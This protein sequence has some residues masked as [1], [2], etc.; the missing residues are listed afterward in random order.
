MVIGKNY[1][2]ETALAKLVHNILWRME[3]QE[4]MALMVTDLSAHRGPE[5]Q[6]WNQ[7]GCPR[8]VQ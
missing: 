6:I 7:W 3:R 2:C 5:E 1:S 4:I 8:V